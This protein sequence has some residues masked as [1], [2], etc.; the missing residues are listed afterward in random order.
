MPPC[1]EQSTVHDPDCFLLAHAHY[2]QLGVLSEHALLR[3]Y[4]SDVGGR[5]AVCRNLTASSGSAHRVPARRMPATGVIAARAL[6]E[7]DLDLL[8]E[9][10]DSTAVLKE[11]YIDNVRR[12]SDIPLR[13]FV[14]SVCSGLPRLRDFGAARFLLLLS[15]VVVVI[16]IVVAIVT[17]VVVVIL[18]LACL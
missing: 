13:R 14:P 16:A 17:F 2:T 4:V 11:L 1:V 3:P 5:R 18:V 7:E 12:P 9:T 6:Q 15:T 8:T 10:I